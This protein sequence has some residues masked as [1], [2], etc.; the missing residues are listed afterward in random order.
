MARK[1]Y[2]H[3]QLTDAAWAQK[4]RK[5]YGLGDVTDEEIR[6]TYADGAKYAVTWDHVGDA[7]D[8][9]EQLA[10]DWIRLRT[11]LELSTKENAGHV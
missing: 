7:Y 6:E 4:I 1:E 10:D 2:W 5:E 8:D 3:P 11:Q 9:W